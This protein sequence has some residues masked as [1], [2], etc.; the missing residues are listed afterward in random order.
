MVG[1]GLLGIKNIPGQPRIDENG[2]TPGYEQKFFGDERRGKLRLVA[3]P[4]GA[5]GSVQIHQ[6]VSMYASLLRDGEKVTHQLAQGR[7]AWLQIV[8]GN[9]M[10][11]GVELGEGDGA[12]FSNTAAITIGSKGDSELIVFDLA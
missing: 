5:D 3:S 11:D 1:G 6:D 9:V 7:H 10:V 12:S 2:L 4:D 8:R